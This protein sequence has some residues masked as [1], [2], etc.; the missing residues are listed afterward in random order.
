[1]AKSCAKTFIYDSLVHCQGT[2]VLPGIRQRCYYIRKNGIKKWPELGQPNGASTVMSTIAQ[3][4]GSF[5]M[6]TESAWKRID[7]TLNKGSLSWESQG[8]KPARTFLNKATL[9]HPGIDEWACAFAKQ[10]NCDDLVYAIQ[11]RDGKWRILGNEMFETDTKPSGST[12]EGAS[13]DVGL[14]LEI[15]VTDQCPPPFYTGTLF[16]NEGTFD[17]ST[18]EF[19]EDSTSTASA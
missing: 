15:E 13:G 16:T 9:Y 19:K 8:D 2:T 1:M 5:T 10:A 17:C 7:F 18:N 12:G 11:Q 4:E 6:N 14:T 3:F